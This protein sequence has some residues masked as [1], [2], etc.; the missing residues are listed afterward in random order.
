VKRAGTVLTIAIALLW[1]AYF[2][3]VTASVLAMEPQPSPKPVPTA[4]PFRVPPVSVK[5]PVPP[6]IPAIPARA[7]PAPDPDDDRGGLGVRDLRH[8]DLAELIDEAYREARTIDEHVALVEIAAHDV[9][10]GTVDGRRTDR[11]A[12]LYWFEVLLVDKAKPAGSDRVSFTVWVHLRGS[13]LTALR[14]GAPA[15][16]LAM[17]ARPRALPTPTCT[18]RQAW[19]AAVASGVPSDAIA[20]I[21]YRAE[22]SRGAPAWSIDVAGHPELRR[23]VDSRSCKVG[24]RR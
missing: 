6:P 13:R 21:H 10:G 12:A 9:S 16:R 1:V 23:L 4:R 18:S 7:D 22:G 24:S 8:V 5:A 19:A 2:G 15:G 17:A 20:R 14:S 3:L 11:D